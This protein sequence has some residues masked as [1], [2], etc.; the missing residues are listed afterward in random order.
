MSLDKWEI[1]CCG[2]LCNNPRYILNICFINL[3]M[4]QSIHVNKMEKQTLE[5]SLRIARIILRLHCLLWINSEIYYFSCE[6]HF[7]CSSRGC[8]PHCLHYQPQK[9]L[10]EKQE[11]SD[12]KKILSQLFIHDTEN[13]SSSSDP[14]LDPI[15]WKKGNQNPFP[16]TLYT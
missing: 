12:A 15:K 2:F 1:H 8:K 10:G 14:S 11:H 16:Y 7:G 13:F 3:K 6:N 5:G 4:Y 9:S